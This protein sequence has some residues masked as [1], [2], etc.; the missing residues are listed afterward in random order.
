MGALD[1]IFSAIADEL[2]KAGRTLKDQA[3]IMKEALKEEAKIAKAFVA[4]QASEVKGAFKEEREAVKQ[5][6]KE[7][8]PA[9]KEA[10]REEK[11]KL[12][13]AFSVSETACDSEEDSVEGFQKEYGNSEPAFRAAAP[14]AEDTS[15][16]YL[17]DLSYIQDIRHI[18]NG[19]WHQFDFQLAARGY[20]WDYMVDSAQYMITSDL[21]QIGTVAVTGGD[22]SSLELV[23]EYKNCRGDIT[24]MPTLQREFGTLGVGGVSGT[25]G[26]LTKIV[27]INQTQTLR[28]FVFGMEDEDKMERYAET[29][30]RRTFGGK[31]AMKKARPCD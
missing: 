11:Q 18:G 15:S 19:A 17:D 14:E 8:G 5:F 13:E 28:I 2:V 24:K 4:E 12:K 30:I 6:V 3:P 31:D 10:F 16:D 25:L 22:G 7:T 9:V 1:N 27:W 23:T 26:C 29:V 20:G 21:S